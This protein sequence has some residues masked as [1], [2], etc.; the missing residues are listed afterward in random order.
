MT[1]RKKRTLCFLPFLGLSFALASCGNVKSEDFTAVKDDS[2]SLRVSSYPRIQ[3]STGDAEIRDYVIYFD[4]LTKEE[5]EA[6]DRQINEG[7]VQARYSHDGFV[8]LN[9][10]DA[11][12]LQDGSV[13]AI[14]DYPRSFDLGLYSERLTRKPISYI[15]SQGGRVD[16]FSSM[17][18]MPEADDLKWTSSRYSITEAGYL[19]SF[20][21]IAGKDQAMAM[22]RNKISVRY[23]DWDSFWKGVRKFLFG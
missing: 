7:N 1:Q 12:V 19:Y 18:E 9:T 2:S 17:G 3:M 22:S 20:S 6:L 8:N 4:F 13:S 16:V 10:S 5:G 21:V 23:M 11:E 14:G 15:L